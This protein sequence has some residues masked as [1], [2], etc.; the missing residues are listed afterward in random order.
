[1]LPIPIYDEHQMYT[2][3]KKTKEIVLRAHAAREESKRLFYEAKQIVE[4]AML[5]G[6]R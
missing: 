3:A 1:M 2:I 4:E 6:R 5:G